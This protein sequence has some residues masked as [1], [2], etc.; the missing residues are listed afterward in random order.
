LWI[1]FLLKK[2]S[3]LFGTTLL[4]INAALQVGSESS[5]RFYES[6]HIDP[7]VAPLTQ[8]LIVVLFGELVPMTIARRHPERIAIFLA[9]LMT[10]LAKLLSPITWAFDQFS[11]L[12]H[13]IISKPMETPLFLSREEV[14]MT[15][16]E[17]EEGKDE[18]N[19]IVNGVFQ[20]KSLSAAQLM[21]P[22]KN[23][24]LFSKEATVEEV[25]GQFQISQPP[26]LLMYHKSQA[27]VVSIV[28]LRDL[29][30]LAGQQKIALQGRS[31]WFV[32]KETSI[33]QILDQFRRNNE[34]V[35]VILERSGEACGILTLDQI[36]DAIFGPEEP[37]SESPLETNFID[38]TL[39][40]TMLVADFNLQFHGNLPDSP[41]R[42][43]NDLVLASM[44]HPP[45]RGE[46]F[47][48]G[49]Y[50]ITVLEPSLRGAK[51]LNICTFQE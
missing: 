38:R 2:P 24:P 16:E 47:R 33:L 3:R 43:L 36:V 12:I 28:S 18:F 48:I 9:P 34:S 6:I 21:Q 40:G 7:D 8:V 25:R 5:R 15:F 14:I 30:L 20:L 41:N 19:A 26:F 29:F 23:I 51:L 22:I 17:R 13:K 45:S 10:A 50:E 31:P 44:D 42:T 32:A 27:N 37:G 49:R 46:T 39:E 35:A 1:H 11:R 4:G